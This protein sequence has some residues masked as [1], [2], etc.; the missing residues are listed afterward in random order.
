MRVIDVDGHVFEPDELWEQYLDRRFHDRRPRLV[1]DERGTTRYLVEGRLTPAGTG[2]GA[3]V[4][5]G[6]REASALREGA[7][8]ARARLEDMDADGIDVAVLYGAISLGFSSGP[9]AAQGRPR[10]PAHLD[11]RR[12]R[13]GRAGGA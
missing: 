13:R 9:R 11:G 10:H 6:M 4:P 7:V 1:L 3:W 8:D 2:V 5:E 12:P